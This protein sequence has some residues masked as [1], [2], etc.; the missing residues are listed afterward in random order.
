LAE[1]VQVVEDSLHK[2]VLMEENTRLKTLIPLYRLGEKFLTSRTIKEILNELIETVS[3]QTGAQ[4]ISVMLYDQS[5]GSLRI[6]AAM[7]VR[8]ETVRKSRIRPGETIAGRVFQRG[9]PVIL[10]GGPESNPKVAAFLGSKNIIAAMSF[11]LKSR[12]KTLGV[13]NISKVGNGTPF[14][15]ADIEMFSVICGQAALALDNLKVLDERAEKVRARTLLEQ[16][17]APEVAEVLISHGQNLMEVGEIKDITVL[18]AD[19]RNFTP[20]VEQLSLETLR[21]FLN[22][23]FDLLTAVIFRFKGTLDKFM[24]DATLAFFGAPVPLGEPYNAA[25]SAAIEILERFSELKTIWKS[26]KQ[27]FDQVGLGIGIT[28]GEMFLGNVGSQ[29]RFDYTVIGADVNLAQRLASEAVSGEILVGKSVKDRLDSQFHVTE[30]SSRMLRG[31]EKPVPIFSIA[32][33]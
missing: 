12:D 13:L 33:E 25:V 29:K 18:F 8:E 1:L 27:L 20:L 23:F 7:G 32:G 21:S 19:I 14:S 31:L 22:D 5:Q 30:K 16:Y 11:P 17:V 15:K 10:N 2:A 26:K 3:I 24:G 9:E 4:R 6:E 28:S